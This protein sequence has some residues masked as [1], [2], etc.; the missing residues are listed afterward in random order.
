[1]KITFIMPNIGRQDHS[2]YVDEA[3]MEPLS[4]GVLAGLTP[5][6]VE[7]V[8]YDDRV[9]EIPYDE[10]TDLV[11]I[12]VE[13]YTAKR[14]Y[15]IAS[16]YRRRGVPV[17]MGGFHAT[18]CPEEVMQYCESIVI[19]EAENVFPTV[20]DDYRH[21]QA[22]KVYR[23]IERPSLLTTPDRSIF[24]GKRY[25]PI[26]LVEFARGCRFKCDFCAVQSF[27]D[28][29]HS[30]RPIDRVVEEL[31]RVRRAGQLV[32]FIDD[33][34]SSN[35]AQAKDLMRAIM[36]L[37]LKW[38]SQ[39]AINVA[40]DDEALDLMRRSGCQGMLVGF[41][42]LDPATLKQMN[43]GFNMM[44][45]GPTEA[46]ANFRRHGL[47]IYGT[48][49]FGYDHDTPETFDSTV[50]FAKQQGLAIAAFNHI[51]PFP[52][53]P[54]YRR[55]EQEGRLLYDAWWLD[56]RYRYNMIP[57]RPQQISPQ[58]LADLCVEARR[59]FYAW[60]SI[61]RRAAHR[62][63]YRS[64]WMLLNFLVINAMHQWDIE[65]RNGLPLG[66]EAW[67]GPLIKAAVDGG[68]LVHGPL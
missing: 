33:N 18:L 35:L 36:P 32:F 58:E 26:R 2:L 30:H 56:D 16:E 54:L 11:A 28:A 6:D 31:H 39:S 1:M 41:E 13:T 44:H 20:I 50:N 21:G 12:S 60:P 14:A 67:R 7:C 59:S 37:K 27:F 45:G 62:V 65:G 23:G 25:L 42:S 53:T 19:G 9:E 10:P 61:L 4:L 68:K 17:V 43:K 49:I 51:T 57:F 8:L 15:Q 66:D 24:R 55:M 3:R 52:G 40:Y 29:T 47:R 34:I 5:P 46:L 38:I 63:N 48:F 64:P 22:E